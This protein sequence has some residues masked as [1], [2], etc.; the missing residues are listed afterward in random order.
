MSQSK[1]G[2]PTPIHSDEEPVRKLSL[3]EYTALMAIQEK[4][5]QK[6]IE[7][8]PLQA[9]YESLMVE[10]GLKPG[11]KILTD[12]TVVDPDEG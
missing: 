10:A 1:D 11:Q 5:S 2:Q 3:A 7:L 6:Q 8:K 12:R 9:T 4:I